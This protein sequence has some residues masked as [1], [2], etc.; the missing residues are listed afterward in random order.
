[1]KRKPENV[2]WLG[3]ALGVV[4]FSPRVEASPTYETLKPGTV[5]VFWRHGF[6]LEAGGSGHWLEAWADDTSGK[7]QLVHRSPLD[8]LRSSGETKIQPD[9]RGNLLLRLKGV[10]G[11]EITLAH[12]R[13]ADGWYPPAEVCRAGAEAETCR[14]VVERDAETSS[15][16]FRFLVEK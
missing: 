6:G 15:L 9:E 1:M 5:R 4:L 8:S 12:S 14:L 3:L 7:P 10:R 2:F 13:W 16:N 11:K